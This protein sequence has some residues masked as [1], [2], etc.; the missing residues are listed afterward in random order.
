MMG[1]KVMQ[2]SAGGQPQV[3][4]LRNAQWSPNLLGR[5]LTRVQCVDG[6]E[7]PAGSSGVNQRAIAQK[8]L[9][10]LNVANVSLALEKKK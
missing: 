1:L 6:V 9:R 8:Y 4:L 2:G 3:K 7:G 5:T 10:L